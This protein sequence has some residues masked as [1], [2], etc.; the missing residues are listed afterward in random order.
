MVLGSNPSGPMRKV[1]DGC[2]G[3]FILAGRSVLKTPRLWLLPTSLEVARAE[4]AD[5]AGFARLLGATVPDNW[6][7]ETLA[8]ALPLLLGWLEAAP[9]SLGWFGWHGLAIDNATGPVLAASGGFMGPPVAGVVE[10]GYSVLPQFQ[11]RG[12][13]TEMVIALAAWAGSQPGVERLVAQTEW[14]N[15]ASVRVLLKAG[16]VHAGPGTQ[17]A[18]DRY[19]LSVPPTRAG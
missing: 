17:P 7:P 18:G 19:E 12:Y 10:I 3:G 4:I 5:R 2:G 15:P 14:G 13:A 1:F 9:D 6:P 8:D 16:F 11:G